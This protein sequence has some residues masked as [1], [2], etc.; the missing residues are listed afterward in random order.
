MSRLI[1]TI[2]G[3]AASGKGTLCKLIS[4]DL[5]LYYLETGLYYRAFAYLIINESK[6]KIR[7][8]NF[9]SSI[10]HD[11]FKKILKKKKKLYSKETTSSASKFAKLKSVRNFIVKMQ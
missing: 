11:K 9:I 6:E 3:P 1:I 5:N 10:S 4:Q 7:I 2:D 8:S